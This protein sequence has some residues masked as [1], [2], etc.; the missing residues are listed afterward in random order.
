MS[1]F[2]P[3]PAV[4]TCDATTASLRRPLSTALAALA[5]ALASGIAAPQPNAAQKPNAAPKPSAAAAAPR[6]AST[7]TATATATAAAAA[8]ASASASAPAADTA[9]ATPAEVDPLE[10]L[11]QRL[12]ERLAAIKPLDAATPYELHVRVPG[13]VG[14]M[15]ASAASSA[16]AAPRGGAAAGTRSDA[17]AQ[18]ARPAQ[19]NGH[20]AWAYEGDRGP[21]TWGGLCNRGRM[22]SPIDIRGGLA[23]ALEPVRFDYREGGFSVIDTGHTVQVN[24]APGNH[25]DIG[26]KRFELLQFHFHRPS[27]ER[28]D[29]RQF[30]LSVHLVHKGDKGRLAVVAVLVGKGAAR[31]V[32]DTVFGNLPL[33]Q[34]VD[35]PAR[36]T[37][38]P[39]A[40]LPE[41]RSYYTYM[42]SMTTPPCD[43]GV[44]W[45]VMRNPVAAGQGQIDVF[46]TLY[47]NNA[48][49]PQQAAGR[50]ILQ[51][52]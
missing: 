26:G 22:Q 46:S 45:V 36:A 27:E 20:A 38:D 52:P 49:P 34:G 9:T 4:A 12:T 32:L 44:R 43:E 16:P 14:P 8:S 48:R 10:R 24:V 40:L 50:R 23:V 31:P 3:A 35:R 5:L 37:L 39:S 47:P 6:P 15:A 21:Q 18:A 13:N 1:A 30:E 51:T 2:L 11:R 33:E 25:I 41:D 29:G 7:A 17:K 28:L 19:A 42:G